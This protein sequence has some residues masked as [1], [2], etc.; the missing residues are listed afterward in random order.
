MRLT[1]RLAR[2]GLSLLA[3]ALLIVGA[4]ITPDRAQAQ[5]SPD[6]AE[7]AR[8]LGY[9]W[10]DGSQTGDMWDATAPSG[11]R[12]IIESLVEQHGGTWVDRSNLIFRLP[13]PYDWNDWQ[14]GLP[15]DDARTREAVRNPNFLGA[16]IEGEGLPNGLIY[17]QDTCCTAGFTRGRMTELRALLV[18]MGMTSARI[19]QTSDV[20]SGRVWIDPA[21][22]RVLRQITR[23]VCPWAG[24]AIR[25]PGG[26]D[27]AAHGPIRWFGPDTRFAALVRD[28]CREGAP[29]DGGDPV[30]VP[31]CRGMDATIV[32]S[33]GPDT[34]TGTDGADVIYGGD[35]DDLIVGLGGNDVIC[36]G[37][38]DDEIHAGEGDDI[39]GGDAGDDIIFGSAGADLL[40]GA[41]GDDWIDGG[42]H[43]DH[44]N[45]KDGN[46][47][48]RGGRGRDRIDGGRG[49]DSISG[50]VDRDRCIGGNGPDRLGQCEVLLG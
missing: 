10:A 28:D 9:L 14:D 4:P 16:V 13:A 6:I 7:T 17:D 2:L 21:D 35:G 1:T 45:G 24:V 40:I 31:T 27:Y 29:I 38:G 49:A 39:V 32:G 26:E 19:E 44:I 18:E 33:D 8:L 25:V 46:D 48:L 12:A 20:D 41:E 34:L 42:S 36:G 43:R 30:A 5:T 3:A 23:Y 22:F 37:S 15:D 50:G 47:V 11:G